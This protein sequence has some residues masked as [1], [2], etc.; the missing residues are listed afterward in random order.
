MRNIHTFQ[1]LIVN[2]KKKW[3]SGR[4]S[5]WTAALTGR[6]HMSVKPSVLADM[7][8]PHVSVSDIVRARRFSGQ[9]TPLWSVKNIVWLVCID[10]ET[11]RFAHARLDHQ[12]RIVYPSELGDGNLFIQCRQFLFS[13]L[14]DTCATRAVIRRWGAG[15]VAQ[16]SAS[17]RLGDKQLVTF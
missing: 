4:T 7:P 11:S 1:I 16:L 8:D 14:A 13:R 5:A 10:H 17:T 15:F 3:R 2:Q 12:T 6:S 9:W